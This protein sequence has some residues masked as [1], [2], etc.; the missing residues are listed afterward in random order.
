MKYKYWF[1]SLEGISSGTKK[2]LLELFGNE[3]EIYRMPEYE[4]EQIDIIPERTKEQL[5]AGK[6]DCSWEASYEEFQKQKIRLICWNS[7]EY[8]EKLKNIYDAPYCL[9]VKGNLPPKDRK[10]AAVVGARNCSPYGQA[11]AQNIGKQ[12][13]MRGIGI[14]SGLAYGIDAAAHVG[15]IEGKGAAYGILG[16]GIDICYPAANRKLYQQVEACGGILSEYGMG[17]Q[18]QRHMFPQRNRIISG[19]SDVVIVV[20]AKKRS[21]S[22][23]TA[24]RALEQGK[25]V[26]AVPGRITDSLSYG[27]NWLLSQGATP[28]YS[29]EE[30]LKDMEILNGENSLH[31]NLIEFSL[32]KNERLVYS[33]LDFNPQNLE[34]I[35]EKTCLS[36]MDVTAALFGLM[37]SGVVK[38][39][40]RNYFVKNSL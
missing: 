36:L 29:L 12:L 25:T 33:V 30:F 27:C 6:K 3:E 35:M 19:L 22:L 11:V 26:Y 5:I 21:G 2:R 7:P 24:D 28:F 17:C 18:P 23:I 1:A 38:E 39:V 34:T 40:Y 9:Y 8:P 14:I 16:C 13:A 31:K 20:E 15:A 4:W 37:E 32:E 10:L